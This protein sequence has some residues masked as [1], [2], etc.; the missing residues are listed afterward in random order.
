MSI[1][2]FILA[3]YMIKLKGFS[4][5]KK[6]IEISFV[7]LIIF[8]SIIVIDGFR[9]ISDMEI[10]QKDPFDKSYVDAGIPLEKNGKLITYSIFENI[11]DTR[12]ERKIT[13][14]LKDFAWIGLLTGDYMMQDSG[15][16]VALN[17][18]TIVE[19]NSIYSDYMLMKWT[20]IFLDHTIDTEGNQ[21]I[22][23][24]KVFSEIETYNEKSVVQTRYGIN[25]ITYSVSLNE[26][27]LMIENES[28]FPG[29][30]ATLI[31]PD[32]QVQIQAIEVNDVFRSWALPAGEYEMKS[33]FQFPNFVTYQIISLSAFATCALVIVVFW[34]KLED[35]KLD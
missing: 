18:R 28:F 12:P 35:E 22:L 20:P 33:N 19:S 27:Q 30:T 1:T 24:E 10:W 11:P 29:W 21:I 6:Q 15:R 3:I 13:T 9:V 25:E 5:K 7:V 32:K 16:H 2:L 23:E 26:P 4:I 17:S 34:R 31:Y 8:T 14:H